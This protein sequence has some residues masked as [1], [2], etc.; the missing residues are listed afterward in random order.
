MSYAVVVAAKGGRRSWVAREVAEGLAA[1]GL[2]VGGF[3]QRT[4]DGE[5][6]DKTIDL[7]HARDGRLVPL[8][9]TVK[10]PAPAEGGGCSLAFDAA[11]FDTARRWVEEDVHRS[12]VLVLDAIG[13]L[14]LGGEGH[15]A[16]VAAAL[17]GASPVVLAI[18]DDQL[19][20][21]LEALGLGEPVAAYTD[22]EGA[23]ALAEFLDAVARAARKA[24]KVGQARS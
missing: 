3:T 10:Q 24:R 21:A 13:K 4:V 14:E 18:R 17:A 7:V 20:Y 9:R 6:G 19:V 15:R 12:D 2:A 23:A 1:R 8:A 16:A 11:G 5:G 22:G